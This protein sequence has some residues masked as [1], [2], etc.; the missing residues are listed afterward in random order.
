MLYM[1]RPFQKHT[2][3]VFDTPPDVLGMHN[4][5]CQVFFGILPERLGKFTILNGKAWLELKVT[6]TG[7]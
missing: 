6:T 2:L 3:D 4:A 5:T 7:L 1:T